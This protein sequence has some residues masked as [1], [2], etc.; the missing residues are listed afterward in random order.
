MFK[1]VRADCEFVE[2]C[3]NGALRLHSSFD[4]RHPEHTGEAS[5]HWRSSERLSTAAL[6]KEETG[7]KLV[8][9]RRNRTCK[10]NLVVALLA[11]NATFA[12]LGVS[13]AASVG[14]PGSAHH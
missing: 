8:P 10:T 3:D 4:L 14:C 9:T 12:R 6:S 7:W 5:S 2:S 11:L 13:L 1:R